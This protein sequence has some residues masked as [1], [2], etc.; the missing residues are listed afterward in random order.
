MRKENI[1][2]IYADETG[3]NKMSKNSSDLYGISLIFYESKNDISNELNKLN[4]KLIS[5]KFNSM[6]H[7]SDLI[8]NRKEYSQISINIKKSLFNYLFYFYKNSAISSK[9]F[10]I[11]KNE[12]TNTLDM[13]IKLTKILKR[14][15][16]ENYEYISSFNQVILVYDAG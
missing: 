16:N 14:F 13:N 7:I 4:T 3:D 5:I 12:V 9:S 11:K 1:L 8:M 15:V 10:F 2:F 6:L